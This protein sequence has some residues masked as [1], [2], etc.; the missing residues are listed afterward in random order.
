MI[1]AL[2]IAPY[3]GLAE[4]AKKVDTPGN[5][6]L[7]VTIANL[8]EG[9]KAALLA[10]T[11]GYDLI[12]SRGGTATMIQDAVSIPVVHIDITGY[13]MLRVFTLIRGIKNGVA[14]VGFANISQGAATI[15]NILEFDVKMITIKSRDE[16]KGHLERL[17]KEGFTVVIGD[18][19][20]VQFAEQVGLRGV[21]I[22]SGKEAVTD[23]LEEGKRVYNFFRRVNNHFY[24]F[25]ETFRSLPYPTVLL[26]ETGEIIEKN[27]LYEQE[28]NL[29]EIIALPTVTDICKRVLEFESVQWGEIEDGSTVYEVQGF[30]VNKPDAIVGLTIFPGIP[31]TRERAIRV[32]NHAVH[33]P[34]IGESDHAKRLR[35]K[36]AQYAKLNE[37]VCIIGE[38]GAGKHT[39]AQEIH[40]ERF[41]QKAP[42]IEIEA[43]KIAEI[44]KIQSKLFAIKRGTVL[45]KGVES[46]SI[47][48]QEMIN[49][50]IV[51]L[52]ET[53]NVIVIVTHFLDKLMHDGLIEDELY[54]LLSVN[55]LHLS[56]LRARKED[57]GEFVDYFLTEFHAESGN[58][59]VGMKAEAVE[60]LKQWEWPGNL[61][62]L[63]SVTRE[64]SMMTAANYIELSHV[65]E[66]MDN[67]EPMPHDD[68]LR[69]NG[70]LEEM[71]QRIIKQVLQEEGN[72]QSKAAD[73]LGINR[74]TLWRRLRQ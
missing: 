11:Q 24:H 17:K 69:I 41:G 3:P 13:D 45:L 7:D 23:A 21:L 49:N 12:I 25:Q 58:E 6:H 5:I 14:L 63:K 42:V 66:L 22:T 64:L 59:T 37:V 35:S 74:S 28:N 40:F 19:I 43:E 2:L 54:Q 27:L 16:V 9:V 31:K 68:T 71:E 52:P 50:L 10:E 15:C 26:D 60:Y 39:V 1:K 36:I 73:R 62:Q 33:K 30:L 67:V 70:T 38:K 4:T 53:L 46:A 48:T 56:P 51:N 8:E 34:I 29:A 44:E 72:N 32:I 18:V 61:T 55:S 57:I 65:K 20:T 47:E